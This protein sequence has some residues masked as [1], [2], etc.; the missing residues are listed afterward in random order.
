[1]RVA[2]EWMVFSLIGALATTTAL[3]G[4]VKATRSNPAR[5]QALRESR[6]VPGT[7][8]HPR[9]AAGKLDR[10]VVRTLKVLGFLGENR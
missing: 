4:S 1:M 5:P 6:A 8:T 9:V 7:P 3:N 10:D 2:M